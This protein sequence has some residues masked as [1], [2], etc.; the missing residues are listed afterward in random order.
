M[1]AI[2]S[3]ASVQAAFAARPRQVA[4]RSA[5]VTR[6]AAVA[7]EVPSMEKRKLMVRRVGRLPGAPCCRCPHWGP[8]RAQT[9]PGD[10]TVHPQRRGR[11]R[12]PR[13]APPPALVVVGARPPLQA[14]HRPSSR[15]IHPSTCSLACRLNAAPPLP[16]APPALARAHGFAPF[17][18]PRSLSVAPLP[19][20][21]PASLPCGSLQCGWHS[22][23][24]TRWPSRHSNMTPAAGRSLKGRTL[25][26]SP[27]HCP[28]PRPA[29]PQNLL[30]L[31]AVGAPA[32]GLAGP[33]AV[34]FVPPRCACRPQPPG[35]R[36]CRLP[37]GGRAASRQPPRSPRLTRPAFAHPLCARSAGGGAGGIVAKDALGND[38]KASAWL[39]TH[40]AGDRSLTQ[41]LKVRPLGGVPACTVAA[42]ALAARGC[43]RRR[44]RQ[45]GRPQGEGAAAARSGSRRR[46]NGRAVLE[47]QWPS[48]QRRLRGAAWPALGS[49]QRVWREQQGPALAALHGPASVACSQ[50]AA[51]GRGAALAPRAAGGRGAGRAARQ[52]SAAGPE[53]GH[54]A[55]AGASWRAL[56]GSPPRPVR[57][58]SHGSRVCLHPP[59][60]ARSQGDA[61]YLIVTKEGS[62]EKYGLNAVC[63]HLGCVVPW[64]N[65]SEAATRSSPVGFS[66]RALTRARARAASRL[67]P[68]A[69][70]GGAPGPPARPPARPPA[71]PAVP[72]PASPIPAPPPSPTTARRRRRTS[73]CAPATVPSTTRRAR[74]SAAPRR[75]R[76]RSRT[77]TST[78][79][80]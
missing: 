74:R 17:P 67:E 18:P 25:C 75:C 49:G 37:R 6:A 29:C 61:T 80:W 42:R 55:A 12:G 23:R 3:K 11:R 35:R 22:H 52:P 71:P 32:V 13:R 48:R 64:N 47:R 39:K 21:L 24:P 69:R 19:P 1:Q 46:L 15:S 62:I 68:R 70:G 59:P 54:V 63:T 66:F 43:E 78:T 51:A 31:G 10:P 28:A 8:A 33:Y 7:G 53:Q 27:H 41:G 77:A 57:R 16:P 14:P 76:W 79:T 38:V 58:R 60:S 40:P 9:P 44:G 5:A 4:R 34:F 30:L 56:A 65:V 50:Q 20:S 72:R 26:T 45:R 73:S 2:S 36:R